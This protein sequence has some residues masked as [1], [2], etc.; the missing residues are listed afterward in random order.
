MR[1]EAGDQEAVGAIVEPGRG[2]KRP[3]TDIVGVLSADY[4]TVEDCIEQTAGKGT[5]IGSGS[6]WHSNE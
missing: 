2:K 6:K 4:D 1:G 3:F 5:L